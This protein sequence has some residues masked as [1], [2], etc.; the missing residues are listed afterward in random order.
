[1]MTVPFISANDDVDLIADDNQTIVEDNG[2]DILTDDEVV[3]DTT[4]IDYDESCDNFDNTS[5]FVGQNRSISPI[6]VYGGYQ[7][8]I[9]DLTK[10]YG[11]DTPFGIM[12]WDMNNITVPG[13]NVNFTINGQ[14]YQRTTNL[15]GQAVLAINLLSGSYNITTTVEGFSFTFVNHINI[16]TTVTGDDVV[17]YYKN[18]TQYYATFYDTSGNLLANTNVTFNINGVIYTRT[19]NS[20][21]VA[22]L[23]I[24]LYPGNYV[25]TATN[26]INNEPHANTITVLST[27]YASDLYM[28]QGDGSK[29]EAR[30]V[31][32]Q[33]N[34]YSGQYVTF[35]INGVLYDRMTDSNGI[36]RLTINLVHGN[37]VITSSHN[38]LDISNIIVVN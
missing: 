25:I 21:G 12:I 29:F 37:Y 5:L 20:N 15:L 10:Y 33:G 8:F 3:N 23:N 35:N 4:Q 6:V 31:D 18:G 11:D 22:Q 38:G 17:K 2:I 27:L 34:P 24:N 36:A 32:G 30:L 13:M 26:P 28:N 14:T 7:F 19:T 16:L 9:W 1:M